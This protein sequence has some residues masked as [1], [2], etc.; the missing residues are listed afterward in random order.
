MVCGL[1]RGA[2]TGHYSWRSIFWLMVIY[3]AVAVPLFAAF[4]PEGKVRARPRLD[5]PGV[6]L[7]GAGRAPPCR[8]PYSTSNRFSQTRSH[9]SLD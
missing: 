5:V 9:R 1:P 4:V 8:A 6:I 3:L 7:I 2:L